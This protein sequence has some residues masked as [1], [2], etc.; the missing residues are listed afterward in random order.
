MF[1]EIDEIYMNL[2]S[3]IYGIMYE[4]LFEFSIKYWCQL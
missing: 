4:P 2:R 3:Y 1:I